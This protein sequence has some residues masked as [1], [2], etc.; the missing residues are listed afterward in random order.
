MKLRLLALIMGVAVSGRYLLLLHWKNYNNRQS[1]E[2]LRL[3]ASWAW[4]MQRV[5]WVSRI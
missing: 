5:R 2:M 1:R 3:S 4:R